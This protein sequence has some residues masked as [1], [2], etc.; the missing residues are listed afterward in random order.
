MVNV[1]IET[2]RKKF[3]PAFSNLWGIHFIDPNL[4]FLDG[5]ELNARISQIPGYVNESIDVN[6]LGH[7]IKYISRGTF[8]NTI[9]LTYDEDFEGN[10]KTAFQKWRDKI[11]SITNGNI[12]HPE[13]Y[14][15]KQ[16]VIELLD[17]LGEIIYRYNLMGVYPEDFGDITL[18]YSS[19]DILKNEI[20]LSYDYYVVET[21]NG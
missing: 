7:K 4:P 17:N 8:S 10:I 5:L 16:V 1:G 18:D 20:V 13:E 15:C 9:S 11:Y 2:F 12:G 14:K 19:I 6:W 3:V 21:K